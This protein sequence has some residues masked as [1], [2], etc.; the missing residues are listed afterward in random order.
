[1]AQ[2]GGSMTVIRW[3]FFAANAGAGLCAT[4]TWG[5]VRKGFLTGEEETF[6]RMVAPNGMVPFPVSDCTGYVDRRVP[7]PASGRRIGF[8]PVKPSRQSE[9]VEIVP[10]SSLSIRAEE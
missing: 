10:A 2:K 8:V 6:C 5:T 7:D 3:K 9:E 4:C 1:M